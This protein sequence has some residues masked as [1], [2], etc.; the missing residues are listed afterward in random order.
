MTMGFALPADTAAQQ[1]REKD[2]AAIPQ[3]GRSLGQ[4]CVGRHEEWLASAQFREKR[5]NSL[6]GAIH[7]HLLA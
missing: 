2:P 7:R 3:E 4:Q 5:G 6:Y 1:P